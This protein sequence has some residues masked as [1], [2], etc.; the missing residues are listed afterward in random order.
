[1]LIGISAWTFATGVLVRLLPPPES[2]VKVM[3][4]VLM[5]HD[6]ATPVWLLLLLV[7]I[8]PAVCEE[9]LF[10]GLIMTGFRRAGMGMAVGATAALFGLMHASIYRLAPVV[11]LGALFGYA[12]WRT[13]SLVPGIV[14]HA[15]N[16]GLMVLVARYRPL[17]KMLGSAEGVYPPWLTV[18]VGTALVIA[19]VALIHAVPRRDEEKPAAAAE[20][21]AAQTA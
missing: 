4:K 5:I 3:E 19:G 1:V 13:G 6:D 14:G 2:M 20:K 9:A 18:A 12:V 10:R 11:F 17:E 8:T 21:T 16:N 7:A 15:L